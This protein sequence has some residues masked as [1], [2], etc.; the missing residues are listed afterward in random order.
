[1]TCIVGIIKDGNVYLGGD[2]AGVDLKGLSI[3]SRKD[4]KVF[5]VKNNYGNKFVVGYTSSFRMGQLLRFSFK[6]PF[7]SDDRDIY[8]YMCTDFV[9]SVRQ[10]FRERGYAENEKGQES[11]GTFLVGFKG[12]LFYVDDDYQIGEMN[13]NYASVGCGY[14]YALGALM[15]TEN[16]D[17]PTLSRI[18]AALK[19][20]QKFSAGVREPFTFETL[21]AENGT[22]DKEIA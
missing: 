19:A 3:Q 21:E 17:M 22:K 12:R 16:T 5:K 1:M 15:A 9:E 2:S 11:G 4:V 10:L 20:A 7:F 6:P 18:E 13:D 8:E 14:P